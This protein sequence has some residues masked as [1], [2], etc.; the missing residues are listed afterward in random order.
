MDEINDTKMVENMA[1][2]GHVVERNKWKIGS[3]RTNL[4]LYAQFK[5]LIKNEELSYK[6][7]F[8]VFSQKDF[9]SQVSCTILFHPNSFFLSR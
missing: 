2:L 9:T 3:F 5:I 6:H 7:N 4:S 1:S 8:W